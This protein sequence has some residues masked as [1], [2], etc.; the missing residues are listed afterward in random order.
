ML[1]AEPV[2]PATRQDP[3]VDP[4]LLRAFLAVAEEGHFGR[5]AARLRLAQP[6]L[7]RQVQQLE[8]SLGVE[9]FTRGPAGVELTDVGRVVRPEAARALAQNQRLVRTARA[10]AGAPGP[11]LTVAAPMPAP[12]GGLLAAAIR[13]FRA[14]HGDL[15]LAVVEL[16][17]DEQ[18]TALAE[19]RVDVALTWE[20]PVRP[21][22]TAERLL[23]EPTVA[24]L[25]PGHPLAGA[26]S[27]PVGAFTDGP[28]LFP[29]A[30]RSHC[31]AQLETLA[32]GAGVRLDP[33]PT[34]PSAVTDLVAAGLGISAVPG[35]FSSSGRSDVA[36][37]PVPGLVGE[38]SVLWRDEESDVLVLDFL[39]A[40]RAAAR[41]QVAGRAR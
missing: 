34:A 11:A 16:D 32:G 14:D 8:R 31:W 17:D 40:C 19:G 23:T 29:V 1:P 37:V 5:A 28:L 25:P 9:L 39:D 18:A 12:P 7:S 35:S 30:E 38:M 21:G 33:I 36:F 4:R 27:F 3:D 2:T 10:H 24:L 15:A 26:A 6:A 41:E 22:L 13:L 20:R